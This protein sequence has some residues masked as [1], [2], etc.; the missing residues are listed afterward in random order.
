[1]STDAISLSTPPDDR[2]FWHVLE[3]VVHSYRYAIL[4]KGERILVLDEIEKSG[5]MVFCKE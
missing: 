2:Y 4:L 5:C 3:F 1:M